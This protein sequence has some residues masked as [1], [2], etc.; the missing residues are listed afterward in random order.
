MVGSYILH[1]DLRYN[2]LM[3]D[4]GLRIA[5]RDEKDAK[6]NERRM[7]YSSYS[8]RKETTSPQLALS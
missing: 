3:T 8:V 5:A 6:E 7:T 1:N 4:W 2:G